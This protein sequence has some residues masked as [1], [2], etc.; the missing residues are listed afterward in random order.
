MRKKWVP[1]FL[2]FVFA[3][4]I[5][6]APSIVHAEEK[7]IFRHQNTNISLMQ[8]IEN[9]VVV[10]G[11]VNIEGSVRD[12]VVVINGNLTLKPTAN[13]MGIILVL[14]GD[15]KQEQGAQTTDTIFHLSMNTATQNSFLFGG[16]MVIGLWILQFILT[17]LLIVFPVLL[18]FIFKN[19]LE[20][21]ESLVRHS[22]RKVLSIGFVVSLLFIAINILLSLTIIGIPI[23]LF[24]VA[25]GLIV[26]LIGFTVAGGM[27]G[28]WLPDSSN[29]PRWVKVIWGT[30]LLA[31]SLNIP[32]LGALFVMGVLWAS[33]GMVTMKVWEKVIAKKKL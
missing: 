32:I 13:V 10:G 3:L 25:M 28:E 33:L 31:A 29:K 6:V 17:T 22:P 20:A 7:D 15:I 4:F 24:L 9:L 27:M 26:F 8:R 5:G 2:A 18:D 19:K 11:D 1:T 12:V 23:V 21:M 16:G 30:F 14:G